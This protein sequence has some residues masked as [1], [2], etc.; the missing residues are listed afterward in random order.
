MSVDPVL[1]Q[2][3]LHIQ[4]DPDEV[5]HVRRKSLG[6]LVGEIDKLRDAIKQPAVNSVGL[7][8]SRA[9]DT[10]KAA[11]WSVQPRSG[12][13]RMKVLAAIVATGNS[14]AT[15]E[16]LTKAI[17]MKP[18]TL[19]PRRVE[20]VVGGWVVDSKTRRQTESNEEAIVWVA[21]D[22]ARAAFHTP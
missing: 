10:S 15:D 22:K 6:A 3:R 16:E 13:Q 20:L 14:G 7:H 18:N 21:T 9:A 12:T 1:S 5:V 17:P 4:G 11:A 2:A 8:R 19:R